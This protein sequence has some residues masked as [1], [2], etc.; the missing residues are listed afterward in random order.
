MKHHIPLKYVPRIFY[1]ALT[2]A[3]LYGISTTAYV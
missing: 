1:W 2:F 3:V